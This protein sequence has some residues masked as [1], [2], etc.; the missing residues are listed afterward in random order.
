VTFVRDARRKAFW[1]RPG[2]RLALLLLVLLL[3]A[4]AAQVAVQERD[5]LAPWSPAR[6]ALQAP[7]RAAGCKHRARRASIESIA[8]DSSGFNRCA[9]TPTG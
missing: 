9:P 6:P 8:I 2:V 7:V 1:R 5:R 4:L 3:A